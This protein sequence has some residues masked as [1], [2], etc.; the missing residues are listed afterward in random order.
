MPTEPTNLDPGLGIQEPVF[1]IRV[2]ID[3]LPPRVPVDRR[4]LRPGMT[5]GANLVLENRSLWQV[6]F[7]PILGSVQ[8]MSAIHWPWSRHFAP[9]LQSEAAECGLASIVMVARHYG[10]RINLAGLRQQY[11]PSVR[12]STLEQLMA[13]ASDLELA[14]RAVRL[15]LDELDKLQK[16]A[17]LHW[18]MNHFVVLEKVAAG[19]ATIVDPASGR[20]RIS[21]AK[22]G[23][24]FTG[25]ALELTPTAAF[26]PIEA[27]GHH[28]AHRPLEP[29][30][31]LPG[32]VH[33]DPRAVAGDP[34]ADPADALLHPARHRRG[35]RPGRCQPADHPA[36]RLRRDLCAQRGL[37][38][39]CA[40]G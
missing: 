29:V 31:Q 35:D 24:H 23:T 11:P 18:D 16:P 28:P 32:P 21:L 6:L 20:R 19:V 33:P 34:A 8:P 39:A 5:L 38:R 10:H 14:P 9:V 22:M 26:K 40:T 7:G 12:G 25:V 1:R 17:I 27:Q 15:E 2:R 3:E 36:D 13:I 37:A 4:N 30:Q